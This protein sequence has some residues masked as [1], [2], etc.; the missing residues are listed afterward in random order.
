M[1][2]YT[3]RVPYSWVTS[4]CLVL[5]E[6]LVNWSEQ[7]KS[8][9]RTRCS[10]ETQR[11]GK[12]AIL[13]KLILFFHCFLFYQRQL[14]EYMDFSRQTFLRDAQVNIIV[15]WLRYF[16]NCLSERLALLNPVFILSKWHWV[17]KKFALPKL[18]GQEP[19]FISI[20]LFKATLTELAVVRILAE[21]ACGPCMSHPWAKGNQTIGI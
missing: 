5:T 19:L 10:I 3:D 14:P 7:Q 20:F 2:K 18:T 15:L 17:K 4:L 1:H 11:A 12:P 6:S 16:R 13:A 8:A 21:K 9:T